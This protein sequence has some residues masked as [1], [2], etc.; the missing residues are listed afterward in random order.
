MRKVVIGILVTVLSMV[1]LMGCQS[2]KGGQTENDLPA[3]VYE[4]RIP[5]TVEDAG[6]LENYLTSSKN[7]FEATYPDLEYSQFT[8][9]GDMTQLGVYNG[10]MTLR[11]IA[12]KPKSIIKSWLYLL[13][14]YD[15]ATR[16]IAFYVIPA[17]SG[18]DQFS[19]PMTA[20]RFN[21][22]IPTLNQ[23]LQTIGVSEGVL[24]ITD[25]PDKDRWEV[26]HS[27]EEGKKVDLIMKIKSDTLELIEYQ[28]NP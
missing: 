25:V 2:A 28:Q 17:A 16:H 21:A 24:K 10:K 27:K 18:S 26:E 19:E 7:F 9:T 15:P 11:Y 3:P 23:Y 13:A 5:D 4:I 22:L 8:Y 12:G 20:D 6:I 14:N 1:S